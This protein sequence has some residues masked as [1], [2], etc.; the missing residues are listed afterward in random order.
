MC[1]LI[2]YN[3]TTV[4]YDKSNYES[5]VRYQNY[6][7]NDKVDIDNLKIGDKIVD[8]YNHPLKIKSIDPYNVCF[9][10]PSSKSNFDNIYK[11]KRKKIF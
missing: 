10:I 7:L 6:L 3:N 8:N 9:I 4:K 11:F 1:S 5:F 2:P